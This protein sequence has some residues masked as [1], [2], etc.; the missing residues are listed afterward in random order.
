MHE[1][2]LKSA[3]VNKHNEPPSIYRL[4]PS[5]DVDAAWLYL[6][7]HGRNFLITADEVRGLGKDPNGVTHLPDELG[8]ESQPS[9][10]C[11]CLWLT[12][13]TVAANGDEKYFAWLQ[14]S[15]DIHCLDNVRRFMYRDY[16]YGDQMDD[17]PI[18]EPHFL[19]CMHGLLQTLQCKSSTDVYL[20]AWVEGQ[21]NAI[22]DV[23]VTR[24]C[25]DYE[26]SYLGWETRS[27]RMHD[28]FVKTKPPVGAALVSL[29]TV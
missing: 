20:A 19:H 23:D 9:L 14:G 12:S 25:L 4:Q 21:E 11:C 1:V 18:I 17:N 27:Q 22:I 6:T 28:D 26:N 3:V 8:A 13:R 5:P 15:H 2:R 7:H 24:K 29:D 16:Y 10:H